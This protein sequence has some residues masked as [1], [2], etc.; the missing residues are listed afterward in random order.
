MASVCGVGSH[1]H[2]ERGRDFNKTH[3]VA[4]DS[5]VS[6]EKDYL[7]PTARVWEPACGDGA[8]SKVLRLHGFTNVFSSDIED[9]GYGKVQDFLAPSKRTADII[10]TNPPFLLA[11]EF[12]DTALE[13]APIVIMLLRL[14]FLESMERM[15]WF[16]KGPLVRYWVASRRL[17]MMHREGYTGKKAG[18]AVAHAWFVWK[19]G[20]RSYP[21]TRWFDW[22]QHSLARPNAA[23]DNEQID[24]EELIGDAA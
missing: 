7:R 1:S 15:E 24:I 21:Q 9:R 13:R 16:Q 22:K 23:N 17:P 8:I 5:I 11:H 10:I 14:A 19:R 3:R 4:V 20:S 2:A 12:V 18:S 6:V